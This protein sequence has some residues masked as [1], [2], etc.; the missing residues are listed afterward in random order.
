MEVYVL[1]ANKPIVKRYGLTPRGRLKKESYPH[2]HRFKSYEY[3]IQTLSDLFAVITEHA[4]VGNCLLKGQLQRALEMESRAGSTSPDTPTEWICLDLDG[5]KGFSDI[6]EALTTMGCGDTD[7]ILQWSASQGLLGSTD[8]RCHVFMLLN[9][10][11][12]PTT[13]KRWLRFLN[14]HTKIKEELQLS[15][16]TNSLLWPLDVTTCQND[17]LLY[18]SPPIF[19]DAVEDPFEG[20]ERVTFHERQFRKLEIISA[21]IPRPDILAAM[22]RKQLNVLRKA[23]DLPPRPKSTYG[24]DAS[25]QYM[26]K[27]DEAQ[28]TGQKS[29]RGFTY[30]NLNGGN[31]WGYYHPVDNPAFI[32]NFKGEPTY[33]TK[34]LLPSYWAE[35]SAR[36]QSMEPNEEGDVYLAFRDFNSATYWN[37]IYSAPENKLVKLAQ[38]RSEGQLRHFM[39]Q[40]GQPIGD[41]IPD[42]DMTFDPNAP[43]VIDQKNRKLNTFKRSVYFQRKPEEEYKVPDVISKVVYHALGSN[44]D[45]YEHFLNWLAVIVQNLS[46]T[47]TAWVLHGTQGTGK[48]VLFN[49]ILTPLFGDDNVTSRRMEELNSAFTEFM[50]NKF[51]VFID[52]VSTGNSLSHANITAKLKNLIV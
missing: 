18:I 47:G 32:Y 41:Y 39:K 3:D 49:H 21:D 42:W 30:F 14:L 2:L 20:K 10:P 50:K 46:M 4:K 6:D 23:A 38:A 29:E 7:Y 34:D 19:D 51:V 12:H 5:I 16:T 22:E 11:E 27:P 9:S 28:I 44:D 36:V 31:S 35:I 15:A 37:G 26:Q 33:R 48:G 52:E 40:H 45:V 24:T 13:L 1:H 25:V 43:Y 17:K 8:I